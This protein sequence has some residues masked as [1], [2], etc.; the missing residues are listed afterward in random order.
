MQPQRTSTGFSA[1]NK[2]VLAGSLTILLLWLATLAGTSAFHQSLHADADASGH[3]CV[4][5]V[6]THG[7]V[8]SAVVGGLSVIFVALC[9]GSMPLI[10]PVML[11][12]IDLRLAP[13]R[14]PPRFSV[15]TT[16]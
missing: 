12:S 3:H 4:I 15:P 11:T 13:S 16:G 7:Q 2:A 14:A 10:R 9:I 8:D 5:C 1:V 6:F